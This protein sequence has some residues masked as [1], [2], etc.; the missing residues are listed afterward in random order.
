MRKEHNHYADYLKALENKLKALE[1]KQAIEMI[2]LFHG[3]NE[4]KKES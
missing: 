1:I 3:E 4:R 2:N